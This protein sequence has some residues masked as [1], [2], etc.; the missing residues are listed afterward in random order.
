M[1]EANVVEHRRR[2]RECQKPFLLL[3]RQSVE[4]KSIR[5]TLLGRGRPH[6]LMIAVTGDLNPGLLHQKVDRFTRP[7]CAGRVIAE[8]YYDVGASTRDLFHDGAERRDITVNVCY[9]RDAGHAT[10]LA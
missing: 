4:C 8:I 9:D 7:K 5:R 3:R 10:S 2:G 1:E 6:D